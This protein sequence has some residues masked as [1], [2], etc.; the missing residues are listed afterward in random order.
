M[1]IHRPLHPDTL[2]A[3]KSVCLA[4]LKPIHEAFGVDPVLVVEGV[5]GLTAIVAFLRYTGDYAYYYLQRFFISSVQVHD[6]DP[7]YGQL[8]RWMMEKQLPDQYLHSVRA[9]TIR[10]VGA[11]PR[12]IQPPQENQ[13]D[14]ALAPSDDFDLEKLVSHG[15]FAGRLAIHL[16]PFQVSHFFRHAGSFIRFRHYSY[17]MGPGSSWDLHT[18]QPPHISLECLGRSLEP[19]EQLLIDV[20]TYHLEHSRSVTTVFRALNIRGAHEWFEVVSRPSRDVRT[21]ILRDKEKKR[22]L[23]KDINECK[24]ESS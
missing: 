23:L 1:S 18:R 13:K 20:Q 17:G 5:V 12:S 9:T 14:T 22:A 11:F 16:Q 2:G 4:L 19:L 6:D 10:K 21:V 7:L 8:M 15:S 3:V 24:W